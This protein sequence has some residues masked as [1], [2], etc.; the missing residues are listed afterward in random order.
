MRS[1]IKVSNELRKEL[2]VKFKKTRKS[3]YNALAYITTGESANSIR[4]YALA[5]GGKY[6]EEDF[7]P[8][9]I[10]R[11][12][13][14]LMI[15]A[16]HCGVVVTTSKKDSRCVVTHNGLIIESYDGL[17]LRGWGNVLARAQALSNELIANTA[18]M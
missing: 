17:T 5:H 12:E 6:E 2:Q 15:Q 9:C 8:N 1:Y 14:D 3:V 10:T 18:R 16:F 7:T 13:G 4:E 11:H